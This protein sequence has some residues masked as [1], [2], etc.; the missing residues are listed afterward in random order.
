VNKD[1]VAPGQ[2]MA[3]ERN[4]LTGL[5]W[6]HSK[7]YSFAGTKTTVV[8]DDSDLVEGSGF[9]IIQPTRDSAGSSV[10]TEPA[11]LILFL[12]G[13]LAPET[14]Y[15]S[16]LTHWVKKGYT[17]IFPRY[18]GVP[19]DGVAVHDPIYA[20]RSEGF[21]LDALAK[22]VELGVNVETDTSGQLRYVLIGHSAGA[23]VASRLA[24][25]IANGYGLGLPSPKA[26]VLLDPVGNDTY[27]DEDTLPP[28]SAGDEL[29][30]DG[31]SVVL[32]LRSECTLKLGFDRVN[33]IPGDPFSKLIG[34]VE[35][36]A[37][38]G[39]AVY[40]RVTVASGATKVAY[41]VPHYMDSDNLYAGSLKSV[42][43][44]GYSASA[45]YP[46]QAWGWLLMGTAVIDYVFEDDFS[47]KIKH[48]CFFTSVPG[49]SNQGLTMGSIRNKSGA[50]VYT[51]PK[52]KHPLVK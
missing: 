31:D 47:L 34:N 30:M 28:V 23:I 13:F 33:C 12:H 40:D 8:F 45:I 5:E 49:C 29:V 1:L 44:H 24:Y 7:G 42:S 16:T 18:M 2:P 41:V 50:A 3:G 38:I 35:K 46:T 6:P 43:E 32:M 14:N 10:S 17:V 4:G 22:L 51:K 52:L 36:G 21:M 37:S 11:K 39:D 26:L 20:E 9:S 27:G 48:K 19:V 15:K 25:N